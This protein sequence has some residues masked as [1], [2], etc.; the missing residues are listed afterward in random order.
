MKF[1]SSILAAA[2]ALAAP[3]GASA[4]TTAFSG[5]VVKATVANRSVSIYK[6]SCGA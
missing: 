4:F 1:S 3:L 5:G 6:K 2:L